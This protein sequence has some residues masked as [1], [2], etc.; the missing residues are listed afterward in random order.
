MLNSE[1]PQALADFYGKVLEKEPGWEEGGFHGFDAGG[2]YIM[3]G[4]HDKVH[5]KA[6]NPERI[7]FFFETEDV[8]GEFDR[9]KGLGG[10]VVA[11]P[12]KPGEEAGDM[13]LATLAD[14][15]GNYFQ[16]ASPMP[17]QA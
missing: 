4:P 3:V 8:K 13:W 14:P 6:Q 10:E 16:L 2:F 1:D 17:D 5:G 11:E 15:D 12:Y 7:L 9:I